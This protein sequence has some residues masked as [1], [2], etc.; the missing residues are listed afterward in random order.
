MGQRKNSK[1]RTG[2]GTLNH[3]DT[4]KISNP[5]PCGRVAIMV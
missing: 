1:T 3:D 4:G 2:E 5:D